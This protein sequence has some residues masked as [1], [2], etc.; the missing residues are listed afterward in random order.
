MTNVLVL[1]ARHGRYVL[2][3]GLVVGFLFPGLAGILR[4][5]L[6]QMI[7]FL[8]FITAFRVGPKEAMLGI[9]RGFGVLKVAVFLQLILPLGAMSAMVLLGISGTTFGIA[10]L[11]MLAAP[12]VTATP[13]IT[14]LL[15]QDPEPAFRLF[16]VGTAILPLTIVPIFWFSPDLGN[17]SEALLAAV[18]LLAAIWCS[19]IAA[20][21]LRRQT[22]SVLT[23]IQTKSVDGFISLVLAIVVIALMSAVTPSLYVNPYLVLGWICV[24]VFANIGSQ[25]MAYIVLLKFGWSS[26]AVAFSVVAGNRNF[27]LFLIAL[28]TVTTDPLLIFL[29]CY[30]LPM[31]LT[32]LV[33]HRVYNSDLKYKLK[34]LGQDNT[35]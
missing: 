8:L 10:I 14:T 21:I 32:P 4:P 9:R 13:N 30:Q 26:E 17:L 1:L 15:G 27:A 5:Y 23:A 18:K 24:A 6:P 31:Y 22:A 28:P 16:V 29:G 19:V 35:K 11:L 20:F 2:V 3:A 25:I 33:M 7:I 34:R 12:S